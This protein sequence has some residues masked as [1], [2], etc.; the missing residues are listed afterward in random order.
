MAVQ[1]IVGYR[2]LLPVCLGIITKGKVEDWSPVEKQFRSKSF[3]PGG[4]GGDASVA[5]IHPVFSRLGPFLPHLSP[6]F[7]QL[8]P[9]TSV[10]T[11]VVTCYFRKCSRHDYNHNHNRLHLSHPIPSSTSCQLV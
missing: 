2:P 8:L 1:L 11:I 9:E 3:C 10:S 4:L 5:E 7:P 6:S